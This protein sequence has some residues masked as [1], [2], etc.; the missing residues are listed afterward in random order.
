MASNLNDK[1]DILKYGDLDLPVT[2]CKVYFTNKQGK[3]YEVELTRL[4]QV[5]NNNIHMNSKSVK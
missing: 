4:I 2:D 5:F 1:I 3:K